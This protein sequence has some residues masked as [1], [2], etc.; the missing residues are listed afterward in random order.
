MKKNKVFKENLTSKLLQR[1]ALIILRKLK[2][3]DI[4]EIGCGDGNISSYLIKNQINKHHYFLSDISEL[5][6]KHAKK[7]I[8][9][10]KVIF[11]AGSLFVPWKG[12][13]FD[14]IISDVS[15]LSQ[16]IANKS[17]WY[18]G[19]KSNCGIDG[20][21]NVDKIIKQLDKNLKPNG[22][23]IIPL[24]SLSNTDQLKKVLKL[25]FKIFKETK[26]IYWPI[27][28]FFKQ[29]IDLFDRLRK[30]KIIYYEKK[31]GTYLAYTSVA[32]CKKMKGKNAK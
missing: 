22:I 23:F 8:K 30:K 12:K 3:K 20:L 24:I 9:Y 25:K 11:K 15:S 29:N 18:Q 27:P 1:E 17:P 31:F 19:V 21:K 10:D 14:I 6:I 2:K 4:C 28:L 16:V 5:A 7:N 26:K 32:I 13:K